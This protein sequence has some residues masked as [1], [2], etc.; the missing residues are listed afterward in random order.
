[1]IKTQA[2]LLQV[3]GFDL[4]R[5]ITP[6]AQ[7]LHS[8]AI[9][10]EPNHRNARTRKSDRDRQT[11]I[12]KADNGDFAFMCQWISLARACLTAGY[13]GVQWGRSAQ[14]AVVKRDRLLSNASGGKLSFNQ[15]ATRDPKAPPDARILRQQ[16][17]GIG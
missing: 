11:N 10:I 16:I 7:F 14:Q 15:A 1:M 2:R 13:M 6:R 3:G 8:F 9:D 17:D 5:P 12:A 4:K